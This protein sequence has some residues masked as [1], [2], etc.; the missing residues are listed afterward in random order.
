MKRFQQRGPRELIQ[1]C[2]SNEQFNTTYNGDIDVPPYVGVMFEM[3]SFS[4]LEVLT[5]ELDIRWDAEPTDLWVEVYTLSGSYA[6]L[7]DQPEAWDLLASTDLV[8]AP[9]GNSAVIPATDFTPV[10]IPAHEKRSFYVTMKGPYLDHTVYGLQKTGDIHIRGDDLQLFVGSGFTG[11]KFPGAIDTVLHPQFA[12]IIHYKK[13]FDCDDSMAATTT[14]DFQFLFEKNVLDGTLILTANAAIE[15][16][17]DKLLESNEV[18]RGFVKE[19]GL[20][21]RS[22]PEAS[23]LSYTCK[24]KCR[25][26]LHSSLNRVFL[27]P[28][29]NCFIKIHARMTGMNA[30]LPTSTQSLRFRTETPWIP[31]RCSTRFTNPHPQSLT[32]PRAG[33]LTVHRSFISATK[34]R[35]Q[36]SA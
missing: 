6:E 19:Y 7:F 25:S 17:V 31:G 8:L 9:E 12:G 4:D 33:Y 3:S 10:R 30:L 29:N 21:K 35:R 16:A 5:F 11:Y 27:P 15:L 34:V 22:A 23:V 2:T 20:Q 1:L 32:P 26:E 18:I 36:H 14:V 13:T 28:T 24:F